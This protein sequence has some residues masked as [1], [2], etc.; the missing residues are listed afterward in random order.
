M[1]ETRG[2]DRGSRQHGAGKCVWPPGTML[3]PVPAVLVTC[4]SAAG[5]PNIV[6]VAWAGTVCSDPPMLSI[7]LRPSRYSH[8]LIRASGEFVVNVPTAEQVMAVDRCGVVS[9][10][11][12]DKF[13]LTGLT[14]APAQHVKAPAIAECPVN[15]EC[16]V[17]QTLKLGSHT[18][19]L[20]EIVGVQVAEELVDGHGRLALERTRLLAYAHGHYYALGRQLGFFGFSVRKRRHLKRDRKRDR[21][22]GASPSRSRA[23]Q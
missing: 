19:F 23:R 13:K 11:D 3:A 16:R 18:L 2:T 8:D 14:P 6:T 17:R 12:T 9:G 10:R 5:Q 22:G 7:S 20:A 1:R 21:P 15:L 4:Q